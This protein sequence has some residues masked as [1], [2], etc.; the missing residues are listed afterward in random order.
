MVSI[1]QSKKRRFLQEFTP[2]NTEPA[3]ANAAYPY[4]H[5]FGD[6]IL[7]GNAAKQQKYVSQND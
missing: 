2:V 3:P 1:K 4:P 5:L 7:M 6:R